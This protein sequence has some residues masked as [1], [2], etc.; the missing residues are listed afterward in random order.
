M[1]DDVILELTSADLSRAFAEI[2]QEGI[3]IADLREISALTVRFRVDRTQGIAVKQI[4]EKHGYSVR[5]IETTGYYWKLRQLTKHWI[6]LLGILMMLF[7]TAWLP[8]RVLF[9]RVEGNLSL[10]QNLILEKAS[11]CGI[12]FGA[13]R[14]KVR[15]EQAKNALLESIPQ[16]QWAGINTYGCVAVITV[17][18]RQ[19]PQN[20]VTGA[21]SLIAERDAIVMEVTTNRGAAQVKLGQAVR[22][23][24]LLISGYADCGQV[25]LFQGAEGEV[26]GQ[27]LRQIS[28]KTMDTCLLRNVKSEE[29]RNFSLVIGKK[30]INFCKDS[31]ILDTGCVKMYQEYYMVLPGGLTLPIKLVVETLIPCD[32]EE[33]E[34]DPQIALQLLSDQTEKYLQTQMIAGSILSAKVRAEGYNYTGEFICREMIGRMVYEE[35]VSDYGED[36]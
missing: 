24:E 6:L 3:V 8:S 15:S 7:L 35:I 36:R 2:L 31:G 30:Q 21:G 1:I 27:T 5:Q 20:N 33:T 25:L 26:Y 18:E 14:N 9:L 12:V 17:E 32:L 11:E 23:G 4:A 28:A 34:L 22:S 16:L 19:M 29:I 10:P 13:E